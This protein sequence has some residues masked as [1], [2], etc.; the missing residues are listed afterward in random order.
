MTLHVDTGV[1]YY[2]T[3][4]CTHK[5]VWICWADCRLGS[6]VISLCY[7][8]IFVLYPG[9]HTRTTVLPLVPYHIPRPQSRLVRISKTADE[10]DDY[11]KMNPI[12]PVGSS[13]TLPL[14]SRYHPPDFSRH[15]TSYDG[16]HGVLE[17]SLP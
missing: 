15:C 8:R 16:Q 7:D 12:G 17:E 3:R 2:V 5:P 13:A 11:I 1:E 4:S 9:G 6:D 10:M 14:A